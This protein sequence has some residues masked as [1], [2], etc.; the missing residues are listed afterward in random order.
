[1]ATINGSAG[2]EANKPP[3]QSA[4]EICV[5]GNPGTSVPEFAVVVRDVWQV[6][7]PAAL[8]DHTKASERTCRAW[9]SGGREPLSGVLI[10]LLRSREG[11]LVLRRI[12]RDDAPDWW[13]NLLTLKECAEAY[14][15]RRKRG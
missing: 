3:A 13:V 7:A 8:H 9:S 5:S 10:T 14:E 2:D 15:A 1:M 11:Y 6:K 4:R 12:M